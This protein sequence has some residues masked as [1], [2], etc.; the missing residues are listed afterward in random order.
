MIGGVG[1]RV[2][3][4]G[5]GEGGEGRGVRNGGQEAAVAVEAAA[6]VAAAVG[7]DIGWGRRAGVVGVKGGWLGLESGQSL[8]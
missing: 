5:G 1:G 8:R 2:S 6:M 4:I 3:V 7:N